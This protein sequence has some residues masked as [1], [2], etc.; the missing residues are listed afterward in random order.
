MEHTALLME[1]KT[2]DAPH[3]HYINTDRLIEQKLK[4]IEYPLYLKCFNKLYVKLLNE[5]ENMYVEYGSF[6]IS[7]TKNYLP[8]K[9]YITN[10][11][12]VPCT[13]EE[14]DEA[15]QRATIELINRG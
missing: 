13:Q 9:H 12:Y 8:N 11:C 5:K 6:G 2:T 7:L 14:F 10:E 1:K 4:M 15:W 3:T